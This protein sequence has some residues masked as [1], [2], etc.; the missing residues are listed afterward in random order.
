MLEGCT[1]KT[2]M[3][4]GIGSLAASASA[5]AQPY[6]MMGSGYGMMSGGF[7]WMSLIGLLYFALGAFVFSI[8]FWWVHGLVAKDTQGKRK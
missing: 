1:M 7:V 4:I 2:T 8:V 5:F 3:V 6:D